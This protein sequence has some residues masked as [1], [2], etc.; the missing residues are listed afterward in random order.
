M[1]KKL[2]KETLAKE[3]YA[4]KYTDITF[5]DSKSNLKELPESVLKLLDDSLINLISKDEP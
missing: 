3:N 5:M 2:N 4:K 1:D